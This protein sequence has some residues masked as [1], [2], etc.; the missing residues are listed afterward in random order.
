[1]HFKYFIKKENKASRTNYVTLSNITGHCCS[2]SE[3]CQMLYIILLKE[4]ASFT[5]FIIL[6]NELVFSINVNIASIH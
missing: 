3:I 6:S 2:K 4:N 5:Y 1:M